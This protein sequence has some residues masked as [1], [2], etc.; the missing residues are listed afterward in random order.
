MVGLAFNSQAR[1]LS[2]HLMA[3]AEQ[4]RCT[5]DIPKSAGLFV[6]PPVDIA[7]VGGTTGVT[8]LGHL[9]S[10]G[11]HIF[12]TDHM[13]IKFP[14]DTV[15]HPAYA[16]AAGEIYI[17]MR[18]GVN[19]WQIYINHTCSVSSY[20]IH[21]YS[22]S[23]RIQNYLT[24]WYGVSSINDLPFQAGM[25]LF[26]GQDGD[27]PMLHVN[28]GEQIGAIRGGGTH[29][30]WDVGVI[31]GR[32]LNGQFA[33]L[34]SL[35]YPELV[36]MAALFG[37]QWHPYRQTLLLTKQHTHGS[38]FID[39]FPSGTQPLL[40]DGSTHAS[41]TAILAGG[42]CGQI[43]WDTWDWTTNSARLQGSW[44]NIN[45]LNLGRLVND[46]ESAALTVV[47]NESDSTKI[48]IAFGFAATLREA[49]YS[50]FVPDASA[51]PHFFNPYTIDTMSTDQNKS[52]SGISKTSGTICY[53]L[54]YGSYDY[55]LVNMTDDYTLRVK[56]VTTG[57][58][59]PQCAGLA[60]PL[61]TPDVTWKT[62][63]R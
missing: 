2:E 56:Y 18:Q 5:P 55:L 63:S 25:I 21:M 30:S 29:D 49:K 15:D 9:N 4:E 8:P 32:Y 60:R 31:D 46:Y 44:F 40:H 1:A 6:S 3:H 28:A 50:N 22:L 52:P 45:Y 47:P 14:A 43:G 27:A 42:N 26:L 12:P 53:D 57:A 10:S 39:Y 33:D 36:D 13:Y 62:Y 19:D 54:A 24:G 51:S 16:M 38:C 59:T 58:G 34:S 7:N 17:V 35:R 23:S 11:G 41:W 48:S 20:V 37:V 61:A